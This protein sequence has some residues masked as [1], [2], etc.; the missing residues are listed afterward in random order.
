MEFADIHNHILFGVD[1]G[2][3]TEAD[4]QRLID[5]SY[6]DGVRALCFTPHYHPG[7]FG[8]HQAQ[9]AA[10][11]EKARAYAAAKY[12]ALRLGLGAELRYER[13]CVNW[14]R[15]GRCRT[16]NG[17]NCLLV[18]FLYPE[19]AEHIMQ[20]MRQILN[21]GY[22]P[23]LAHVE[24]YGNFHRDMREVSQLKAWGV[25]LQVDAQSPLGGLGH[26]AKVRSRSLLEAGA[27]DLI[28]SDAHDLD[29]RRPQ[30][31]DCYEFVCKRYGRDYAQS[32]FRD[33][34]MRIMDSEPLAE[35]TES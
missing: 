3:R 16:I 20:A 30:M 4:M 25:V 13:S 31:G 33:M 6:Q 17:T 22:T 5:V 2:A 11:Y 24:R 7:Y 27:V 26:G 32:L 14:V 28:A 12:P 19:P 34:P 29:S 8:E 15:Q 21:D 35:E 9:I 18:D 10:A 23:V 1:D